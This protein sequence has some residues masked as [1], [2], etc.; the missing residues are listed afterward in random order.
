MTGPTK[1][2]GY[3]LLETDAELFEVVD[4][5]GGIGSDDKWRF[6]M[7]PFYA[8]MGGQVGD[9][10]RTAVHEDDKIVRVAELANT[11]TTLVLSFNS[12]KLKASWPAGRARCSLRVDIDAVARFRDITPLRTCCTGR[13]TKSFR[14]MRRKREVMSG[15]TN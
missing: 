13:C 8:E 2:L 6:S 4:P 11:A 9:H 3:D 1:F 15:R 7:S 12:A 10:W 14:A 5:A